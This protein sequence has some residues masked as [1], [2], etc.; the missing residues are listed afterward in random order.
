MT[1]SLPNHSVERRL[2]GSPANRFWA[3]LFRNTGQFPI[4][5]LLIESLTEKWEYLTKPDLYVLI[6]SALIQSWW[7]SRQ[8]QGSGWTRF[9]GNLI[10]P[11]L[12][13]VGET[14][15][16]GM[17]FF[18]SP[19][20]IAYWVFAIW[21]G[22]LQTFQTDELD[23]LT[24]FLLVV[25]NIIRS[26]I[27]FAAYVIFE[28][29]TNPTQS[30]SLA[31]FFSDSSHILIGLVT[32]TLGLSIGLADVSA[33]RYLSIL[34]ETAGQLKIYSEWLLGRDLL[35]R[36]MNSPDSMR[37]SRQKRT[38]L[39]MD[40]RGFT[41]WCERHPP[42]EVASLLNRYY[43]IS[44]SMLNRYEVIKLKFTA[45]Q[46]MAVFLEADE[47]LR[48]ARELRVHIKR[49]LAKKNLGAGIGIHTGLLVEGLLGGQNV[50]F[51]DVIGDTVNTAE[52]IENM[53]HA[54]EIWISGD[55]YA[56]LTEPDVGEEKDIMVKGKEAPIKVYSIR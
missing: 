54:G 12:Y 10:A 34:R 43:L 33:R 17:M 24:E 22:L 3:E 42:E 15:F 4:G 56:S 30:V 23:F 53:A 1:Q 35:G 27:L 9:L 7:L 31:K 29:Y 46:L 50:R 45:D 39:F 2:S 48:A 32:L 37:P 26:Q 47:A 51:Y 13:T 25:E 28:I 49:V 18:Q 20:H 38:V 16:E 52:R 8:T 11:L 19:H 40:I 55:T 44:E 14:A 5:I 36:A 41:R 21:I 6:P